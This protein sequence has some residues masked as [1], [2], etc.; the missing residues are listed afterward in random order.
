MDGGFEV[1]A[2]G[3][4]G[5]GGFQIVVNNLRCFLVPGLSDLN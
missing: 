5:G 3:A 4:T 2:A 1:L